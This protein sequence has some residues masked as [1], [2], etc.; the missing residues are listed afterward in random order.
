MQGGLREIRG[1]GPSAR[2]VIDG[3]MRAQPG[4]KVK[5]ESGTIHASPST[6]G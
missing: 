1:I 4:A 6:E 2:V 3:L 5:P